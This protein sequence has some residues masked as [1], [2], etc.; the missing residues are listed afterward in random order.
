MQQ[1][2]ADFTAIARWLETRWKELNGRLWAVRADQRRIGEPL[3]LDSSD[4]A[5]QRENDDVVDAIGSSVQ[6]ELLEIQEALSRIEAGTYG[7]CVSCGSPIGPARLQAVPCA[8]HCS[9]CAVG[10]AK[11]SFK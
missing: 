2:S 1:Q 7:R 10:T 11:S 4:R 3:S 9:N 8:E 5:T 6:V